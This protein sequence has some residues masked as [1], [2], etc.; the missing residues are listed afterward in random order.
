MFVVWMFG[1]KL[2]PGG[3]D[4]KRGDYFAVP[5]K[6]SSREHVQS[7][8]RWYNIKSTDTSRELHS[9][10]VYYPLKFDGYFLGISRGQRN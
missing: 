3:M 10:P 9:E 7:R 8:N 4:K 1:R 5:I 6:P 2:A